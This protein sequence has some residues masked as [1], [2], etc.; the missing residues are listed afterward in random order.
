MEYRELSDCQPYLGNY[1][2]VCGL[3]DAPKLQWNC[4]S[5]KKYTIWLIDIYPLG[6]SRPS[7]LARGVL[8]W[9]VD[10]PGCNVD[11][12]KTLYEYQPPLPLYGSGQNLY[13]IG[14]F[15]Q[16][17]YDIDWSEESHVPAT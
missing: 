12:G 6:E 5:N 1:V 17:E 3:T 14:V 13:A 4:K 10:I 7:L 8:W 16:P 9:V 11:A 15:E 2:N